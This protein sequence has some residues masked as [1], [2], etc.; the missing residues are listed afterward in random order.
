MKDEYFD[1][2]HQ[3][4][5]GKDF[6]SEYYDTLHDEN[7]GNEDSKMGPTLAP[8]EVRK[9]KKKTRYRDKCTENVHHETFGTDG[10]KAFEKRVI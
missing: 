7:F 1:A 2:I 4:C 3:E 8:K 6:E 10:A 9:K 5:F